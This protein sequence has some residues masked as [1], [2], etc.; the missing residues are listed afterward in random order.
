MRLNVSVYLTKI[1]TVFILRIRKE[2]IVFH[3]I[4]LALVVYLPSRM[5]LEK[6]KKKIVPSAVDIINTISILCYTIAI[7]ANIATL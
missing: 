3:H 7:S 5:S 4:T 2:I 1:R 6:K